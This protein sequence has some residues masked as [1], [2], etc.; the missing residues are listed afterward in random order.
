M[1]LVGSFWLIR[2]HG[3]DWCGDAAVDLLLRSA[4][5]GRYG[6][7][8][9][10]AAAALPGLQP[11]LAGVLPCYYRGT[12]CHHRHSP[13]TLPCPHWRIPA[14]FSDLTPRGRRLFRSRSFC[15]ASRGA[16][17]ARLTLTAW[18]RCSVRF[19]AVL[20]RSRSTLPPVDRW[21]PLG[22]VRPGW[23]SF[24]AVTISPC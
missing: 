20:C 9:I 14:P 17:R 5:A 10:G 3:R 1:V 6:V 16:T 4:A 15:G 13:A 11:R 18:G 24:N 8:G 21:L 23:Q 19:S 2:V 12:C 22:S 7:P